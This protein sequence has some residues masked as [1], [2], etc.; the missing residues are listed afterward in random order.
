MME[1]VTLKVQPPVVP[2]PEDTARILCETLTVQHIKVLPETNWAKDLASLSHPLQLA[3]ALEASKIPVCWRSG[4]L[5]S[6]EAEQ[7]L[8]W[9]PSAQYYTW[10]DQPTVLALV[11]HWRCEPWL[12]RCLTSLVQQSHPLSGIVVL[13]DASPEPPLAIVKDF[14]GVTLLT[15]S[16]RVG[17]YRLIQSAIEATDCDAYLFQD[18][19]DWSSWDRLEVLLE[20]ARAS[21][22]DMLGSQEVRV[23]EPDGQLQ[24]VGYPLEVNQALAQAPGHGL[25]HP[26]SLVT[27]D[28][29][30]RLGGFAT[31]LQFGGDTEFLLRAHWCGR[32]V[33]S[34][35]CCYFRRKRPHSLTTAAET[36]LDS[37][38]RK[39]LDRA[40]KQRFWA[41]NRAAALQQ[42][43]DL[44]PLVVAPSISLKHLWGPFLQ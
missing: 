43:L 34:P 5:L 6:V 26:T 35:R 11:P 2:L 10:P 1:R 13:D 12:R 24:V 19:D 36:G 17:P 30:R 38:T 4:S 16:E 15:A 44:R 42:P 20:M 14:P 41:M 37:P 32:I 9:Q 22:A 21:G 39:A 29:I 3:D 25:L 7:A 28:L 31:G 27:R 18:A 23:L 40:V 8:Q 33:N